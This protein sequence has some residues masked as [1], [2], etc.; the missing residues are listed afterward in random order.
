MCIIDE[1]FGKLDANIA[2]SMQQPLQYLKNKYKNVFVIA[3]TEIIKDFMEFLAGK[4]DSIS[5]FSIRPILA[6]SLQQACQ[7][8]QMAQAARLSA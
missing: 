7:L 6:R 3:H 4:R 2:M 1:G 5:F 8:Y